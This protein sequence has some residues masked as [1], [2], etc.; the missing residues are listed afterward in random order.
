MLGRS[1]SDAK[2]HRTPKASAKRNARASFC[3]HCFWSAHASSRR[4]KVREEL[5]RWHS[6]DEICGGFENSLIHVFL[7]FARRLELVLR[8]PQG[9]IAAVNDMQ[10]VWHFHLA[11]NALQQ[12]QRTQ[13]VA[14]P[15]HKQDGRSQRA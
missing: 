8:H 5:R 7:L 6:R 1:K 10:K 4:S 15:L 3:R 12:I 14:C 11:S 9:M 2:T 13:R